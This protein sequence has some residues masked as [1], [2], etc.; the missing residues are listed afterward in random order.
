MIYNLIIW[1][2]HLLELVVEIM[3]IF[4]DPQYSNSKSIK[5]LQFLKLLPYV[6]QVNISVV[7]VLG[8]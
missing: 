3:E 4:L 6:N 7:G 1:I 2:V 5:L 8:V